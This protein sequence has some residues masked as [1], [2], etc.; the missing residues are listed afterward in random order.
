MAL[1]SRGFLRRLVLLRENG[2][3]P[4]L[5]IV[6]ELTQCGV[7]SAPTSTDVLS[8]ND[9]STDTPT[10]TSSVSD[11]SH[12]S[13]DRESSGS[14][15]GAL[16]R[17]RPPLSS[18]TTLFSG[19]FPDADDTM[20]VSARTTALAESL[21]RGTGAQAID[22]TA[23]FG[24]SSSDTDYAVALESTPKRVTGTSTLSQLAYTSFVTPQDRFPPPSAMSTLTKAPRGLTDPDQPTETR[25][26]PPQ[27][28][29]SPM[30]VSGGEAPSSF[31]CSTDLATAVPMDLTVLE[32]GTD[33]SPFSKLEH[34]LASEE[35]PLPK[36]STA[37]ETMLS[38]GT[39]AE[40]VPR[41]RD[42]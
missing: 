33:P 1:T 42:P 25:P 7:T 10:I 34:L 15:A 5:G 36:S 24:T 39:S 26:P 38:A 28:T 32:D 30:C 27:P 16:A 35:S 11:E 37:S 9:P 14:G 31:R 40:P 21:S 23:A 6:D 29:Q 13:P 20:S 12:L 17:T 3:G 18:S 41:E 22:P 19:S 2:K 4:R 8:G